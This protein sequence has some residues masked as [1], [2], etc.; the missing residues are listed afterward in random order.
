MYLK[1]SLRFNIQL[2]V[3]E[4][5]PQMNH[6]RIGMGTFILMNHL[7]AFGGKNNNVER[8]NILDSIEQGWQLL[9]LNWPHVIKHDWAFTTFCSKEDEV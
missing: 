5:L 4:S 8:L 9:E 3:W 6:A 2:S 1:L 7:Y